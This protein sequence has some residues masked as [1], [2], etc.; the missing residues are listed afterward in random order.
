MARDWFRILKRS[1]TEWNDDNC[2]QIGAALS[3]Y[4][5]TSMVPLLLVL[6]SVATYVTF[7]T[8]YGEDLTRDV[9]EYIR[10]NVGGESAAALESAMNSR[11]DAIK[12]DSLIGGVIGFITLLVAASSIFGQLDAAFDQIWNVPKENQPQGVVGTVRAKLLSFGLLLGLAFLLLVSTV[13]TAALNGALSYFSFGPAWLFSGINFVVQTA[14]VFLVFLLLFKILPSVSLTWRDVVPGAAVTAGLWVVGQHLLSLYFARAAGFSSYGVV[15]G[16][17]AFI[18]YV[19]YSSQIILF[20][21]ELTQ[22]VARWRNDP[23]SLITSAPGTASVA[24][25]APAAAAGASRPRNSKPRASDGRSW[26]ART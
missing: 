10:T 13:L 18:V 9:L 24:S 4:T 5:L 19:Y 21:G 2:L 12:S 15:G 25:P 1:Y 7:F 20:G 26:P 8:G 23:E 6:A 17:L 3:F 11:R 22:V 16:L 14:S